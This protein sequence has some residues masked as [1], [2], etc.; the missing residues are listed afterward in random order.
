MTNKIERR[1]A[2]ELRAE[3]TP[4]GGMALTGYAA[5]FNSPSAD[6]GGFKETIMPGAFKRSI[7]SGADV[8]ALMNHDPNMVLGRTKNGTLQLS[9]DGT[10]LRFSCVLPDTQA[11]RDLHT[12]VKRGD[13]DSCSFAFQAKDQSW[14]DARSE[15]GDLYANRK[16]MDVDLMDVSAVTYPAYGDT[17]VQARMMFGEDALVEVRSAVK[18]LEDERAKTDKGH[19]SFNMGKN[20]DSAA[21]HLNAARKH[22]KHAMEMSSTGQPG[23]ND[24]WMAAAAH[25]DAAS[26]FSP[27]KPE[28]DKDLTK[29]AQEASDRCMGAMRSDGVVSDTDKTA[30]FDA[31]AAKHGALKSKH[32]GKMKD[33]LLAG[34]KDAAAAHEK[35]SALHSS[36]AEMNGM[37]GKDV[38]DRDKGH[39]AMSASKSAWESTSDANEASDVAHERSASNNGE[40]RGSNAQPPKLDQIDLPQPFDPKAK[41]DWW[42]AFADSYDDLVK[43]GGR[44]YGIMES[45]G[46]AIA[47][48]NMAVPVKTEVTPEVSGQ[49]KEPTAVP[50]EV[51]DTTNDKDARSAPVCDCR[52]ERCMDSRHADCTAEPRC[53][54][55]TRS[56]NMDMAV[57]DDGVCQCECAD[58]VDGDCCDC[59]DPTCDDP[60]CCPEE[61]KAAKAALKAADAGSDGADIQVPDDTDEIDDRAAKTKK[62]GGKDLHASDFA[63]VGDAQDPTTWKLRVHDEAHAKNTLAR[64]SKTQGIPPA[65]KEQVWKRIVAAAKKFGVQVTEQNSLRAGMS[66][67]LVQAVLKATDESAI[68][69]AMRARARMIEIDLEDL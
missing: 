30:A 52:C 34:H 5:K 18:R 32:Y 37:A 61:R 10:G 43:K 62:K 36:A 53:D 67:D 49:A 60:D 35:A 6:L 29:K 20:A 23:A 15:N 3:A 45:I 58:C 46:K 28:G 16:L 1:F 48:A 39:A 4:T 11:A 42:D 31:M 64:F 50:H 65:Q 19:G 7:S 22:A 47:A 63:F 68:L 59:S 51:V 13:I 25:Y 56:E 9:E 38:N 26:A 21:D 40:T 55:A 33:E 57:R 54:M 17:E 69:D 8:R 44:G 24:H 41:E 66:H 2:H 12:L 14:E 27:E